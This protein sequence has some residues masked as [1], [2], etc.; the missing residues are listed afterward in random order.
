MQTG[1]HVS[2]KL[3]NLSVGGPVAVFTKNNQ[4]LRE[5]LEHA[6]FNLQRRANIATLS[7]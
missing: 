5:F 3:F 7:H 1:K 2:V 4:L 6:I